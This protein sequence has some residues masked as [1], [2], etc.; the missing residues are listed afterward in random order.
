ME[1]TDTLP[2]RQHTGPLGNTGLCR[3]WGIMLALSWLVMPIAPA[4]AKTATNH[5]AVGATVQ[6]Y[7]H[8]SA[9]QPNQLVIANK[10]VNLGYV[11][12]PNGSNPSGTQLTIKTNDRAGYTLVFQVAPTEQALFSSIQVYGLG[13]TVTLP[14]TGGKVTMTFPGPT[15]SLSLTYRFNLVNKLKDG[16][17]AWPLTVTGQPN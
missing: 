14:A 13:T 11:N 2:A 10:D 1:R 8:L 9:T 17:Y 12:V 5:I 7:A 3:R 6:P 15:A 4:L 16:T